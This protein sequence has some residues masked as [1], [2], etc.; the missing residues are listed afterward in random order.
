MKRVYFLIPL[1][2]IS[3]I[4]MNSCVKENDMDEDPVYYTPSIAEREAIIEIP[5][6][7]QALAEEGDIYAMAAIISM[8]QANI[9]SGFS[10]SFLIPQDA[11]L[12]NRQNDAHVYYWSMSGYSYWMTYSD[13]PD[14]YSWRY[15]YEFPDIPR[16][17]YIYAEESKSGKEGF[18]SIHNPGN[19]DVKI[20]NFVWSIDQL[21]NFTATIK[22]NDTGES[23]E[24]I[25]Q[26]VSNS[27]KSGS[28]I[29]SIENKIQ[30]EVIWNADG[31]GNYIF[32]EGEEEKTGF[33]N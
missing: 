12:E 26:I 11:R 33:W 14:K 22:L 2:I 10:G 30:T 18:W 29:Y 15:E 9:L 21:N 27:D 25:Y 28:F 19:P 20:W 23:H 1:L 16:F 3:F 6:G 4:I 5:Q 7:L 13:L 31:T 24:G 8:N 32:M 17:T